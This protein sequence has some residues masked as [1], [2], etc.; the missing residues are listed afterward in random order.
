MQYP[1]LDNANNPNFTDFKETL[2]LLKVDADGRTIYHRFR[3]Q[4]EN[5]S[6]LFNLSELEFTV[7]Y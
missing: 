5:S 6:G 2:S 3:V 4:V 1:P 7:Q